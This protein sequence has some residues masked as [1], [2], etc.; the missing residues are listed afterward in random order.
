MVSGFLPTPPKYLDL[1]TCDGVLTATWTNPVNTVIPYSGLLIR[2]RDDRYDQWDQKNL[3]ATNQVF[4]ITGY[5][6]W[7]VHSNLTYEFQVAA[8]C[9]VGFSDFRKVKGTLN[10]KSETLAASLIQ[11]YHE[12][13]EASCEPGGNTKELA[14]DNEG[15]VRRWELTDD[16]LILGCKT[17][18]IHKCTNGRYENEIAVVMA[19]VAPEVCSGLKAAELEDEEKNSGGHVCRRRKR[20]RKNSIECVRFNTS[21]SKNIGYSPNK[22][23]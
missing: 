18:S 14:L 15:G 11:F 4:K 9:E 3:E 12:N 8:N 1:R 17:V 2:W 19:D 10:S 22:R 6:T 13:M 16:S 7:E 20:R 21:G 5:R 23:G